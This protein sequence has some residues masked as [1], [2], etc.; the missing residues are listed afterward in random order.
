M[1]SPTV[2]RRRFLQQVG[3]A[4]ALAGLSGSTLAA[5]GGGSTA[6]NSKDVAKRTAA[7]KL[8]TYVEYK[9]VQADLPGT[10]DGIV[11]GFLA[12]PENPVQAYEGKPGKNGK[13]S[14]LGTM[15]APIPPGVGKNTYWQELNKRTG[16]DITFTMVPDA[17]YTDK[18]S[19]IMASDDLPDV[20]LVAGAAPHRPE[21]LAA[22]FQDLTEFLSGDAVKK[23]P[24][25]ANLPTDS[26]RA[27][28]YNGG[29]FGLPMPRAL[30]GG[31][32][33]VRQDIIEE[34]GLTAQPESFEEF[35]ELCKAVTDPK[36]NRWALGDAH[37]AANFIRAMLHLPNGWTEKNGIFTSANESEE[38][39]KA[40]ETV[41]SMLKE[42]L[43]HPDTFTAETV[44]RKEWYGSGEIVVNFDGYSAWPGF[45]TTYVA[46]N[47]K[48]KVDG[49][50]A[51]GFDGGPGSHAGGG[52]SY[53]VAA[54]KQGSK[55]R[56][57]EV[58]RL[59]NWMAAPFGT[60]EYMFRKY[61]LPDVHYTLKGSDP[62][63]TPKAKLE[64]Q[65][66]TGYIVDAPYVLYLPGQPEAVKTWHAYQGRANEVLVRNPTVGL[67]SDSQGSKGGQIDE[68][69]TDVRSDVFQGRKPM[70]AWDEGVKEWK[71]NG[72]DQIKKEYEESY[73][74]FH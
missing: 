62:V 30:T 7:V 60:Q 71:R 18:F 3:G 38:M 37:G 13:I 49:I 19:V 53:G 4:I 22:K 58:L 65:L 51:P 34:H 12:Y 28:L 8:P 57:D 33:F 32:N 6:Q 1:D 47:P 11:P 35:H 31:C 9:G 41:T 70:S 56:I 39:R 15:Y 29:I 17:E 24:F 48:M 25:L 21:L 63:P 14:T 46:V 74:E 59:A 72:G 73:A 5:C 66:P 61:G 10:A 54:L 64:I 43:F 20:A 68:K 50:V 67:Y 52:P 55:A 16:F 40:I 27:T 36:K 69:L 23:Y 26:W 2:D 42:G 45:V 44:K